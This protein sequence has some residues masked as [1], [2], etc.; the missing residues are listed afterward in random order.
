MSNSKFPP[1][2]I[3]PWLW[4]KIQAKRRRELTAEL[5]A[6]WHTDQILWAVVRGA[7]TDEL[8]TAQFS[9]WRPET[10]ALKLERAIAN[11]HIRKWGSRYLPTQERHKVLKRRLSHR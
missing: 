6:I 4:K 8:L 7:D 10:I 3:E 11:N 5:K 9:T 1:A 2:G